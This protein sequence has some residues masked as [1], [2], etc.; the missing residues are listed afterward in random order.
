MATIQQGII[1][2][3]RDHGGATNREICA[4]LRE[5]GF[6]NL[7][8][9]ELNRLL[10]QLV[11][12]DLRWLDHTSGGRGWWCAKAADEASGELEGPLILSTDEWGNA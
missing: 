10:Y 8:K 12:E 1:E 3:L 4:R 2:F 6:V 9:H 11:P 7:D 5:L